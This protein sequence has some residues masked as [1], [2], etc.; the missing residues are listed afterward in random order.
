MHQPGI[1]RA[2]TERAVGEH[3]N[4]PT[5]V[6]VMGPLHHAKFP[7][8]CVKCGTSTTRTLPVTKLF[9]RASTADRASYYII[10]E[11]NAAF[12]VACIQA[13]EGEL[14][15]IESG[16]KRFRLRHGVCDRSSSLVEPTGQVRVRSWRPFAFACMDLG[17]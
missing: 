5:S 4:E 11:V 15:P 13:H 3:T 8:R 2:A 17:Y 12:C 14:Q 9:W 6:E 7:K 1:E 16:V 10:G